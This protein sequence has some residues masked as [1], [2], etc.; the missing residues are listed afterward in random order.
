VGRRVVAV[1]ALILSAMVT[2][3]AGAT[4][5]LMSVY[6]LGDA[7]AA[8]TTRDWALAAL[9]RV[10]EAIV[11]GAVVAA[12]VF[13]LDWVAARYA[14]AFPVIWARRLAVAAGLVVAVAG[15]AGALQFWI[16]KPWL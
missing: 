5:W 3:Y 14:S 7:A 16:E 2:V 13:A 11:T 10:G 6:F 9:F 4:I 12:V 1:A 15:C 8:F